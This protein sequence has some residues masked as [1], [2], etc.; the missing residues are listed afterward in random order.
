MLSP[1]VRPSVRLSVC[2]V[3]GLDCIQTAEDIVKLLSQL[4]SP[5]ILVF[6]PERR[7]PIPR[8]TTS[9]G[10]QNTRGGKVLRFSTE[11]AIYLG[12]GTR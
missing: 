3:S 11:I 5:I 9:A 1:G 2:H 4:D 7:Y 6:V 10:A 12:H 8:G